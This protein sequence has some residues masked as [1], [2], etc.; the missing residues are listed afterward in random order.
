[1]QTG[2]EKPKSPDQVETEYPS[3]ID[4][5]KWT[6]IVDQLVKNNSIEVKP[7][8]LREF[9]KQQLFSY[10]G[11]NTMDMDQPWINDYVEKMMKDKKFI[12]DSY[13]RIQTDKIFA[14][15]ET[16]VQPIE[17]AIEAEAF[18]KMQQEHHHHH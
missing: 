5:L 2:G 13:H 1:M 7:D 9:A 4:S 16:Q 15:A 11:G 6:L 18:T 10:M 14:W 12:E 8:D 17:K 3:F